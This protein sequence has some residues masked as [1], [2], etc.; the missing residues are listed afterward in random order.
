MTWQEMPL[1]A[2][3]L[4]IILMLG[5]VWLLGGVMGYCEGRKVRA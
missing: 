1:I 2:R 3:W 5:G 4:L